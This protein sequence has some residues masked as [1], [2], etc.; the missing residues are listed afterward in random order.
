MDE[1]KKIYKKARRIFTRHK[2]TWEDKGSIKAFYL[3]GT[4]I[5]V[6]DLD[7]SAKLQGK[8][9]NPSCYRYN[10][11]SDKKPAIPCNSLDEVIEAIE[12]KLKEK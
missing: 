10:V 2:A 11:M 3:K 8:E 6:I 5:G 4:S 12:I 9:G 1:F 7:E